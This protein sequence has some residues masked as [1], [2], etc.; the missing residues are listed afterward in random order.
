MPESRWSEAEI[1]GEGEAEQLLYR[2]RLLGS[3]PTITNFGGGNTSAKIVEEDP[4]TGEP[5]TV[6]WVKGSGGDLG[7]MGLEGF[8]TLELERVRALERIYEGREREDEMVGYLPHCTYAANPRAASIDTPLHAFLPFRHVDHVHPDAVIALAAAR[9]SERLVAEVYEGDIGW[10]AW[11]RP[12]FDLGLRLRD[13]ARAHPEVRGIVLAGHGLFTWGETSKDC[14]ANTL[15][16]IDR[17]ERWLGRRARGEFGGVAHEPYPPAERRV[18]VERLL[19]TLRGAVSQTTRKVGH[20]DDSEDVLAFCSSKRLREL[21]ALGTSCPDHFLRT[22][23]RPLVL[24]VDPETALAGLDGAL[25]GYRTEYAA[26]YDR[27]RREDSPPMRDPNPVVYLVPRVGMITF[28][29]DKTTARL[30][31][32][33]Y[34]NAIH[35]MGGASEIDEYVGLDEQEAFDIEYWQLEEAKLRRQPAPRPLKGRVAYITGGA[36]GVGLATAERFLREDAAVVLVDLD[37]ARLASSVHALAERFG[38]DRIRGTVADVTDEKAV[39]ASFAFASREYGGLDVVVSNAGIASS[40]PV[41]DTTL[42]EW[43]RNHAVLST[44]Y[45]LVGREAMRLLSAQG[46]GGA[47]VFVASKNA[48]VASPGAAAYCVA[49]SSEVH[50]ARCLALEGAARGIRVNTVNPD[51]VLQGSTIWSGEWR[52]QR[53]AAYGIAEDELEQHYVARSLLKRPVLPEDVAQ[54]VYFFAS[55]DSAKSTGNIMNVDAGNAAAF[56]R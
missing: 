49:K 42:D 33:F 46:V 44:G 5:I 29:G 36:G 18:I 3:D 50:L 37:E 47:I 16:A 55:D 54:A 10:L 12:G 34:T 41:E 21:A 26:Y 31:A 48:L 27:C 19:P 2:S 22:K 38:R 13:Y 30:A 6:L 39:A 40:S 17:A 7:S 9:A 1:E 28:A 43:N 35:V 56:T 51:A 23:I 20:F 4:I 25:E 11:Q 52:R 32:E 14:Y 24:D 45:F 53:A 15:D 8:A